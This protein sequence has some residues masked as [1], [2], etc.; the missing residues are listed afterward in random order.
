MIPQRLSLLRKAMNAHGIDVYY[1][2]TS[3]DHNSEYTASKFAVRKFF[4]G[5]TGSAGTLVVTMDHADLWTDGRYFVPAENQLKDTTVTLRK[6][7]QEGVPTVMEYLKS[8]LK[9]K[10]SM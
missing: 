9:D 4:S 6:M 7:G 5:F 2:P 3:D 8:I 10:L 1:I